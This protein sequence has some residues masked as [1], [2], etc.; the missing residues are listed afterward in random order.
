MEID[1]ATNPNIWTALG[2]VREQDLEHRVR[3][4]VITEDIKW[5][6]WKFWERGAK[7][8]A[9]VKL[10]DEYFLDGQSVKLSVHVYKVDGAQASAE[11]AD[12]FS[13]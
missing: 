1:D 11:L 9:G 13:A 3:W 7:R 12:Q 10:F 4:E 5:P 6:W 8:F 2:Y